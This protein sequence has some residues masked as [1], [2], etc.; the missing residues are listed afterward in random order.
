METITILSSTLGS[1]FDNPVAAGVIDRAL[2]TLHR[3]RGQSTPKDQG[4]KRKPLDNKVAAFTS[5]GTGSGSP[6]APGKTDLCETKAGGNYFHHQQLA[7]VAPTELHR[8]NSAPETVAPSAVNTSKPNVSARKKYRLPTALL[9]LLMSAFVMYTTLIIL[10]IL[11]H[12]TVLPDP[13]LLVAPP[14]E[15]ACPVKNENLVSHLTPLV[16]FAQPRSGSNL[17]LDMLSK[18]QSATSDQDLEMVTLGELF[19]NTRT[20]EKVASTMPV[21]RRACLTDDVGLEGHTPQD[22]SLSI[23]DRHLLKSLGPEAYLESLQQQLL[24]SA[25]GLTWPRKLIEAF[26]NRSDKPYDLLSFLSSI[27]SKSKTAFFAFKVFK[28]HLNEGSM[29]PQT[30]VDAL[31]KPR[32]HSKS[33]KFVVLWRRRIIE[34]FVSSQIAHV[35]GNWIHATTSADNAILV[36]KDKLEMYI[37]DK[38]RYYLDVK[39]ALLGAGVDFEVFEYDRD[40]RQV[41]QQVGTMKRLLGLMF[42]SSD[43]VAISPKEI[44][45][46][47]HIEKQA[48]APLHEQVKNWNDVVEW[49]Y[50]GKS[51][52]WEDLFHEEIPYCW[53]KKPSI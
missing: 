52:E 42:D 21:L 16:V 25:G 40:L 34:S 20:E 36:E 48:I 10:S 47:V 19:R 32:R 30:M 23:H 24:V 51:E 2:G 49:G 37:E 14:S 9:V 4:S 33:V 35:S 39:E 28:D 7:N 22:P 45:K 50:G 11:E 38:R 5:P 29:T 41:P 18:M 53:D 15:W 1:S 6:V 26:Q 8:H 13:F 44:F 31:T 12:M 3:R 43:N 27:P 46:H 17:L